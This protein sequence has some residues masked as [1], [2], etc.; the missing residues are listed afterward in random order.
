MH[1][2][3]LNKSCLY[4]LEYVTLDFEHLFIIKEAIA[5]NQK[6]DNIKKLKSS[7][8]TAENILVYSLSVIY[9]LLLANVYE[10]L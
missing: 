10:T 7:V 1:I 6:T 2:S 3:P 4:Y 5:M 9:V 8:I